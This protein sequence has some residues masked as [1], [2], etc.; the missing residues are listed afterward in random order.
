MDNEERM[1]NAIY[2]LCI[3]ALEQEFGTECD[4][5]EQECYGCRAHNVRKFL[6]EIISLSEIEND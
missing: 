1:A 2:D 4:G 6:R 5:S 3:L